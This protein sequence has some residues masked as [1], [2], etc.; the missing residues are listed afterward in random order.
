MKSKDKEEI[1]K[2]YESL[3]FKSSYD[4]NF[5]PQIEKLK[6]DA[7][8]KCHNI[9][10]MLS[11]TI[12]YYKRE[13]EKFFNNPNDMN[14]FEALEKLESFLRPHLAQFREFRD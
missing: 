11:G 13:K 6:S 9:E 12:T 5:N 2:I 4:D 14:S 7:N 1:G 8:Q 10:Q 3:D